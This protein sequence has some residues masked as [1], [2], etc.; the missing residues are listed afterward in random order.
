MAE[1]KYKVL[2]FKGYQGEGSRQALAFERTLHSQQIPHLSERIPKPIVDAYGLRNAPPS[3]GASTQ[4][5]NS[6]Y[7]TIGLIL[8][9]EDAPGVK[10]MLKVT[11]KKEDEQ[12]ILV[13][14]DRK[15]PELEQRVLLWDDK[16]TGK[17]SELS[18]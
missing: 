5:R 1:F 14:I 11:G 7:C 16:M 4:P 12:F 15:D 6:A 9:E 3:E 2:C 17:C 13:P 8:R 18:R 10:E